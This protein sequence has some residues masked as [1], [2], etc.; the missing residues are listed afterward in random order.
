MRSRTAHGDSENSRKMAVI[1]GPAPL[2]VKS[3]E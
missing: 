3:Q 1:A 2:V